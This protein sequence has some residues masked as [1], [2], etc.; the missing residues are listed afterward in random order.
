MIMNADGSHIRHVT[1]TVSYDS[2]PD[3]GRHRGLIPPG[4]PFGTDLP[5][6]AAE[7]VGRLNAGTL[8]A[9]RAGRRVRAGQAA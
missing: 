4:T 1:R 2:Y 9:K 3:W 5:S 6:V 8:A 7:L